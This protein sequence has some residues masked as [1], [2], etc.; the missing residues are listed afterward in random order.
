MKV[1]ILP[2]KL[3]FLL[4]VFSFFQLSSCAQPPQKPPEEAAPRAWKVIGPGGGGGIFL[5]TINPANPNHVFV[6]CDMTAAYVTEDGGK[7][8]RSFNLWTVP[9][10]FEFDPG[11]P[12]TVYASSRGYLYSE[13]RGSGL[14]ILFRSEDRGKRWR[15]IYPA[16]EKAKPVEKLQSKNF[17]PSQIVDGIPDATIQKI[18]VDPADSRRIYMGMAP[19]VSYMSGGMDSDSPRSALL[20]LSTD[21]GKT[22]SQVAELPGRDVQGIFPG[23]LGGRPDEVAVFTE[24]AC[25]RLKESS[26]EMTQLPLPVKRI[27]GAEAG[28][29]EK[30]TLIYILTPMEMKQGSLTGGVYRS[31][32]WGES[33][34]QV[35]QGLLEGVST[36]QVPQIRA[37]GVCGQH[38]E[39]VYISSNNRGLPREDQTAWRYGIFKTEN[40]GGT[41]KPV[42]QTT[43]QGYLTN[44]HKS[45]WLDRSYG[46]GWGGNPIDLGVAPSNPDI[47]Y[48][49]DA[50]RAYRTTDG[51]RTWEQ[52]HSHDQ[53]DGSVTSSGLDVTTCYGVHFDPFDKNHFFITYTDIGLFHT[54]NGGKSWFHSINGVPGPWIN[55]C[56]WLEF[57]PQIRG[58][59]WSVWGNAHDLPR[60]KMFSPRGFDRFQG[61][62]AITDDGGRTW[63]K[64][65]EGIP[66]NSVGTNVLVDPDSPADSRT[67]Y[68]CLFGRGVYKS[69]D[70]GNA[71]QE[72]NQGLGDNLYAWKI[73]RRPGDGRL[74]LLLSRGRRIEQAAGRRWSSTTVDGELYTSDDGAAS[75][76]ALAIPAGEN[77]PHDLQ[78]DPSTPERM[79]L[80][81]W[82]RED[83]NG[84]ISGGLYR[85]EDGGKTWKLAFDQV[86]RVNAAAIHPKNPKTIFINTFQNAAFRSDDCGDTWR[87][88]EG[89]RFKWGQRP[90][91][92]PNDPEMIYLTTYGGSVYYG[93]ANGV[94]GAFEDLE[95]L[96]AA[97]W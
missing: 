88:L 70:G 31:S 40:A 5:P 83:E 73:K 34:V 62:V 67:L 8:W 14:S 79:Y 42:W 86:R 91:L 47:C 32:D 37:L 3:F 1:R 50:G 72:A 33:W 26:G 92:D 27:T 6:H 16:I 95:N 13:D 71:W 82:A 65:G 90:N 45:G 87:R 57:D 76:Q 10:D 48:G 11:D 78:I 35:N 80:C 55:T 30:G 39:V 9:T 75:W 43:S 24:Q 41:W 51:G 4:T 68:V 59:I 93:P 20:M 22:W 66:E 64:S 49:T 17:L 85:T 96:P 46:P 94:P 53:P 56:Y 12:N 97:W 77:A 2:F 69:A 60:D 54:L 21:R 25:V 89:Y 44:N 58:R 18:R 63:R 36:G 81:C 61:G 52:V 23:T 7:N 38:P 74:I 15:V 19:L 28:T 29:G 84:D